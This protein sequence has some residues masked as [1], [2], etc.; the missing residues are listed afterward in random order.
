MILSRYR[1]ISIE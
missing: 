1:H